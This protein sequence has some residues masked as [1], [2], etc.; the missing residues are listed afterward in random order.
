MTQRIPSAVLILPDPV[1]EKEN[2]VTPR[3]TV[4]M[5]KR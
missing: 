2:F 3:P 1:L 5:N 4:I